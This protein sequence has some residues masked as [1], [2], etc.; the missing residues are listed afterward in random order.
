MCKNDK[1][2]WTFNTSEL[3]G[4]ATGAAISN[5]YY[6]DTRTAHEN[7]EKFLIQLGTDALSQV[8]KEFWPDIKRKWFSKHHDDR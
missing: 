6:P 1:G 5:A 8:R 3:L 7:A 2:K 4:N